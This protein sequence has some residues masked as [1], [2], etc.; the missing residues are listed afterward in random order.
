MEKIW[1]RYKRPLLWIA[2]G[3]MIL[4]SAYRLNNEFRRLLFDQGFSGA[5]DLKFRQNDVSRWFGGLPVYQDKDAIYPPAS[6]LML[7]P[8]LGW[9]S[10]DHARWLWA[11]TSVA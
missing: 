10:L 9:L 7:W 6:Y 1:L 11:V 4:A 8:L 5:V 3:L 2:I